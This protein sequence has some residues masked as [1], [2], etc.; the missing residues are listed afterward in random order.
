M[1]FR[2]LR[3]AW[4]VG[5]GLLAVL[6]IVLW[7][8]SHWQA[9]HL[10][11]NRTAESFCVSIDAGQVALASTNGPV[12]MPM[13]W[14][15]VVFPHSGD[16]SI[17]DDELTTILGFGWETDDNSIYV[18]IPF[19][20]SVLVSTILAAVPWLPW[21]SK[22]FSLRTLLIATMLVALLLGLIVYAAR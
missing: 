19:W 10:L 13:D 11:W 15:P 21:W 18:Y 3:I 7:V 4:S 16:E 20:F 1:R 17:S 22:R 8:R 12:M 2:K 9:E 5:W 14:S 6:L